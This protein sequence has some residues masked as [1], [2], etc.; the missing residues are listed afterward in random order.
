M[1]GVSE[2]NEGRYKSHQLLLFGWNDILKSLSQCLR[3]NISVSQRQTRPKDT[4][5]EARRLKQVVDARFAV[6]GLDTN[7]ASWSMVVVDI[8]GR[9]EPEEN[10]L[11]PS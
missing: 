4:L 3:S 2:F 5:V 6:K 11:E 8:E 9:N 1:E 10:Q 7:P